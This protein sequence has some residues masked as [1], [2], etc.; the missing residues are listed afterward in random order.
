MSTRC[1]DGAGGAV[2]VVVPA[3]NESSGILPTL[4][5]LAPQLGTGDRLVV[6]ADNCS[7][8]TASVAAS[9][10][11]EVI[12]RDDMSRVGKGYALAFGIGHLAARPPRFV[13]FVDA[14][15]RVSPG[16][17][18]RLRDACA[19]TGRPVQ[20]AYMM[21][22]PPHSVIDHSV[23]EFAWVVKNWV[24]PLGLRRLGCPV[25]LMGTGMI[26]GWDDI[27][28]VPLASGHLV[29]DLKLGLD[30]ALIGKAPLFLPSVTVSSEFPASQSG[31]ETQ[32]RRWV[33]GHL[34]MI[35]QFV[36]RLVWRALADRNPAPLVLALDLAVPPLSLLAALSV[37][38]LAL[39]ALAAAFGTSALPLALAA[40]NF[41]VLAATLALAWH[42]FGRAFVPAGIT[43]SIGSLIWQKCRLYGHLLLGKTSGRWIRTDRGS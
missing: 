10:G 24:R 22:S 8:D 37:G 40:V 28:A 9:A 13:V 31:T 29:E 2:A 17:I 23:A 19:A 7:D 42:R 1:D 26:F 20:A 16:A 11:A 12:A 39:A 4:A 15:C 25:Q 30:L 27:R 36:P 21:K 34:A 33:R 3:H 18:A 14:D 5:D 6:V 32:R 43:A 41:G 35:V 38:S